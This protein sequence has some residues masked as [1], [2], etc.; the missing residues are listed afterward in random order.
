MMGADWSKLCQT[1]TGRSES[2]RIAAVNSSYYSLTAAFAVVSALSL[3]LLLHHLRAR[4]DLWRHYAWFLSLTCA[5]SLL[6]TLTLTLLP[7]QCV[8]VPPAAR[9]IRLRWLQG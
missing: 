2:D 7:Q 9:R 8:R 6:G 1:A 3:C 5:G 4:I